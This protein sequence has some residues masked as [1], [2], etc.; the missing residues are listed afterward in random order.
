L[1]AISAAIN[2]CRELNINETSQQS[3]LHEIYQNLDENFEL[4][5][6][7]NI[8]SLENFEELQL[9]CIKAATN[10]QHY[11]DK[12]LTLHLDDLI[13]KYENLSNYESSLD[14]LNKNSQISH[15]FVLAEKIA[16]I[17][18]KRQILKRKYQH[19]FDTCKHEEELTKKRLKIELTTNLKDPEKH[20]RYQDEWKI[21]W[22]KRYKELVVEGKDPNSHNFN[23]DWIE[24]WPRKIV[25]LYNDEIT[26]KKEEIRKKFK[27]PQKVFE[28]FESN[29][30]EDLSDCEESEESCDADEE[31]DKD[32]SNL[33]ALL[34][35]LKILEMD[36]L[37]YKMTSLIAKAKRMEEVKANSSKELLKYPDDKALIETV[38]LKFNSSLELNNYKNNQKTLIKSVHE[39]IENFVNENSAT[40]VR[41][42]R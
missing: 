5:F 36:K 6:N 4:N 21:F 41:L 10:S 34:E 7:K 12:F 1:P 40:E 39:C 19:L 3:F 29:D 18:K 42:I 13:E 38:I 31:D 28:A 20:P 30:F 35:K 11:S 37:N 14:I 17:N 32:I 2:K 25:E 9:W 15:S 24:Y 27:V 16:S 22:V 23:K 33:P 8:L 26:E